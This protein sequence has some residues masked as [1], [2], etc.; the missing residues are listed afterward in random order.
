MKRAH[1]SPP[2]YKKQQVYERDHAKDEAKIG[3]REKERRSE[4]LLLAP[5]ARLTTAASTGR[6]QP[7]PLLVAC[8]FVAVVVRPERRREDTKLAERPAHLAANPGGDRVAAAEVG[9]HD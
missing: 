4:Q 1:T 7:P 6:L 9:E 5:P 2:A 8:S 3:E